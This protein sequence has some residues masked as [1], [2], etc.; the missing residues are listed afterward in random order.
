M[1]KHFGAFGLASLRDQLIVTS[2][3]SRG[4][5]RPINSGAAEVFGLEFGA[6]WTVSPR[7][8]VRSNFTWQSPRSLKRN[9]GVYNNYL[10]GEAQFAWFGRAE[11]TWKNWNAWYEVDTQHTQFYDLPNILPAANT[12]QHSVGLAL[13]KNDWDFSVSANNLSD[14]NVEDFNGFPKPGRTFALVT[15]HSF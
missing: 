8:T 4:I 6:V 14:Q 3:D 15:T 11:Y 13:T 1:K 12:T 7:I 10:P 5:G 2:Y 9:S